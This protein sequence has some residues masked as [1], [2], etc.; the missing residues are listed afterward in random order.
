[1]GVFLWM[2]FVENRTPKE[3]IARSRA[4]ELAHLDATMIYLDILRGITIE[5]ASSFDGAFSMVVCAANPN[6]AGVRVATHW[7]ESA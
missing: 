3:S 1:M 6:S 7:K 2:V 5:T 4:G